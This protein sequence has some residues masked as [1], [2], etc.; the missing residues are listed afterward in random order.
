M[1]C[2]MLVVAVVITPGTSM[3][4]VKMEPFART[5]PPPAEFQIQ[6][7]FDSSNTYLD[8]GTATIS[9]NGNQTVK[10]SVITEAKSSVASIGGTVYL[11][12]WT[13]TQ[14]INVGSAST[15][16]ASNDWYFSGEVVKPAEQGYYFRARVVHWINHNGVYEQGET[17]SDSRLVS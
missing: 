4:S 15:I 1:I 13:G 17:T 16:S 6:G 10:I 9:D 8:Q 3:A 12:K 7:L 11:Q 2:I 5:A 14:W